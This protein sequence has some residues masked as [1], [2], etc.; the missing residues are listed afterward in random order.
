MVLL[1]FASQQVLSSMHGYLSLR[2]VLLDKAS[3][4]ELQRLSAHPYL[5]Y[6]PTPSFTIDDVQQHNIHGYRGNAIS[7]NKSDSTTRILFLGGS[8]TYSYFTNEPDST[9]PEQVRSFLSRKC[10]SCYNK[11]LEVINAGLPSGTSAELLAHYLFKYRYYNPDVVVIH[12][13]GNDAIGNAVSGGPYQP[14]LSHF[15]KTFVDPVSPPILVR[16]LLYSRTMS[17]FIIRMFY[18]EY[19]DGDHFGHLGEDLQCKWYD[20]DSSPKKKR[21]HDAFYRNIKTLVQVI[22]DDGASILLVPFIG[23]EEYIRLE[24]PGIADE[25]LEGITANRSRLME[26]SLEDDA[27]LCDLNSHDI[28]NT[29]YWYDDCHLTPKGISEKASVIGK[30]LCPIIE[31]EE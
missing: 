22:N 16:W 17:V 25:Y 20:I 13:G 9:L 30:C 8:T 19:T 4:D 15:R 7:L 18:H 5:N 11:H 26:I 1:E 29:S 12:S 24:W 6:F 28:T 3:S 31:D 14:D 23:N 10:S 21:S 2:K 27:V